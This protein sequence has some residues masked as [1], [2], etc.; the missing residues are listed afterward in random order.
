M[1]AQSVALVL[2]LTTGLVSPQFHVAFDD[3]FETVQDGEN[4]TSEW[5]TKAHFGSAPR[6]HKTKRSLK[7]KVQGVLATANQ[8]I[9]ETNAG[10]TE[11]VVE[12]QDSET[13]H[14]EIND[15]F[16]STDTPAPEE[17]D[18]PP[19]RNPGQTLSNLPR[20]ACAGLRDTNPPRG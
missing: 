7:Q 2:S 8:K 17:G 10:E 6:P 5:M 1:H 13:G 16:G 12:L 11:Q 9:P 18:D 20:P 3:H 4:V 19:G 15:G 14:G